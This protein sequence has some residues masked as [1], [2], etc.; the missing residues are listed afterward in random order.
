MKSTFLSYSLSVLLLFLSGCERD[1]LSDRHGKREYV[2]KWEVKQLQQTFR[3]GSGTDSI[4]NIDPSGYFFLDID[5]SFNDNPIFIETGLA[6]ELH[7]LKPL[8]DADALKPVSAAKEFLA[9]WFW[10]ESETQFSI[11]GEDDNGTRSVVAAE[12]LKSKDEI[13]LTYKEFGG[14]TNAQILMETLVLAK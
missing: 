7:L 1:T 6:E 4:L 12:M 8:M 14:P 2:G 3:T 5:Q 9:Y 10:N 13:Q 11:W